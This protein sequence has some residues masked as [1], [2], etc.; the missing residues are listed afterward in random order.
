MS[1]CLTIFCLSNRPLTRHDILAFIEEGCYFDQA[2]RYEP[3]AEEISAEDTS[4]EELTI[5]YQS[6][7]RPVVIRHYCEREAIAENIA[8][9]VEEIEDAKAPQH[10]AEN[11]SRRI[12]NSQQVLI[13]EIG[14]TGVTEDCWEMLDNLQAYIAREWDGIIF[15]SGEAIYDAM[16]EPILKL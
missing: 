6:G 4:W 12:G 5:H 11:I 3:G 1:L 15:A 8:E 14:D 7:K 9:A 2:P 13:L 16:L 10:Q